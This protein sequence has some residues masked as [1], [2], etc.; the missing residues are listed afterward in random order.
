MSNYQQWCKSSHAICNRFISLVGVLCVY[1]TKIL[2]H[3]VIGLAFDRS[4]NTIRNALSFSQALLHS[5]TLCVLCAVSDFFFHSISI[6]F[7]I[8]HASLMHHLLPIQCESIHVSFRILFANFSIL[9]IHKY[10]LSV[11]QLMQHKLTILLQSKI[12]ID[13]RFAY[14]G[15]HWK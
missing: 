9:G 1:C 11:R 4:E 15:T 14:V 2:C 5:Y 6:Y 3:L 10:M 8:L 12:C 7:S 13:A